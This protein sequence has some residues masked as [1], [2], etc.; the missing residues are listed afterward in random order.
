[1]TKSLGNLFLINHMCLQ[2]PPPPGLISPLCFTVNGPPMY[3]SRFVHMFPKQRDL[4][5]FDEVQIVIL[6]VEKVCF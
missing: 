3:P 4:M 1:M 5:G 2:S 6:T